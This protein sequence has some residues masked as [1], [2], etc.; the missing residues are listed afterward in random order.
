[1]K[2]G[3]KSHAKALD[4]FVLSSDISDPVDIQH[5]RLLEF[6]AASYALPEAVSIEDLANWL[7]ELDKI[8]VNSTFDS[9]KTSITIDF[10]HKSGKET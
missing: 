5:A 10:H 7:N 6:C 2:R 3:P 4:H 1:M 9:G 8:T